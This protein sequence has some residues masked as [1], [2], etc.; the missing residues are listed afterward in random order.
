[1][2][3]CR[4]SEQAKRYDTMAKWPANDAICNAFQPSRDANRMSAPTFTNNLTSSKFPSR[5]DLWSGVN[6]SLSKTFTLTPWPNSPSERSFSNSL[7][8]PDRRIWSTF[9]VEEVSIDGLETATLAAG[10]ILLIVRQDILS[11]KSSRLF[12]LSSKF[13]DRVHNVFKC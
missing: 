13:R 4:G 8:S 10:D 12:Y 11:E 2:I 6:P 9:F 5:T 7:V 3:Q 1:M